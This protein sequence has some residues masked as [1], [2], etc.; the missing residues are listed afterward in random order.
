MLKKLATVIVSLCAAIA[1]VFSG[2][3][4]TSGSST[5]PNL[6]PRGEAGRYGPLRYP[7]PA[8]MGLGSGWSVKLAVGAKGQRVSRSCRVAT[9]C[10]ALAWSN[11]K[12]ALATTAYR[13]KPELTRAMVRE[14]KQL[15]S[16]SKLKL[17]IRRQGKIVTY[18][19]HN[20]SQ[21]TNFAFSVYD[22]RRV[23][24]VTSERNVR[25]S[26]KLK[27]VTSAKQL[28]VYSAYMANPNNG[29]V[30]TARPKIQPN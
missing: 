13:T 28:A 7:T 18:I 20:A 29:R 16:E 11:R 2:A 9:Q 1:F 8:T 10:I 23:G 5:A 3:A 6:E 25:V 17:D 15:V 22:H 4:P 21:R 26:A 24:F 27:R 19:A 14:L 12:V 30:L